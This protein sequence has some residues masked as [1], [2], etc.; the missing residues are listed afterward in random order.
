MKVL[1]I[2]N[3]IYLAQSI[4][5]KLGELGYQCDISSSIQ[6]AFKGVAYDV[7]L[8]STNIS[9]QNIYPVIEAFRDAVVI[10]MV[11]YI[12][13][14]TVT[15]PLAAGAKDYILKPFMI[16]ELIRKIE[17]F[18]EF[19][20]LKL[21]NETYKRYLEQHF[22]GVKITQEMDNLTPP[23]FISSN[24]QKYA[25]RFAFDYAETNGK[26]LIY[27]SLESSSAFDDIS[28]APGSSLLYI[29]DFQSLKKADRKPFLELI[30]SRHVIV[31]STDS[32]DLENVEVIEIK[33]DNTFFEQGDILPIED[34]VKY[35]VLNYQHKFP[36][37]ELSKK[38]GISRKSL[39]EKRKKYGIVK[40]K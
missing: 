18:Q 25:D 37:T 11:S 26:E 1:I 40:K 15:K 27:V 28:R 20:R 39:W 7:V 17:H 35:I 34:Y 10:L 33:S 3:E 2:E 31:S 5:G 21:A 4:A 24:F 9:G 22:R 8:L 38:L 30:V 6:D 23:V 32:I 29:T 12:S 36:D 19:N 13:N 16:E 14:D